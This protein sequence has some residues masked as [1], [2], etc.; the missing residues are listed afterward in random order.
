MERHDSTA[1]ATFTLD[2]GRLSGAELAGLAAAAMDGANDARGRMRRQKPRQTDR[3]TRDWLDR[4]AE[5]FA[6]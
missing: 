1:S 2:L 4:F 3:A 5:C 6:A